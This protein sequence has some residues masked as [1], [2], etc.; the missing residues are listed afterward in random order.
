LHIKIFKYTLLGVISHSY[1]IYTLHYLK[2]F[3][4]DFL[5]NRRKEAGKEDGKEAGILKM[6]IIII[7][8]PDKLTYF[9]LNVI[10]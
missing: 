5:I 7:I 6:V 10:S 9:T 4:I 1:T 2:F 8:L 3:N